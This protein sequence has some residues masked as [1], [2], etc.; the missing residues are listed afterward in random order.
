[1]AVKAKVFEHAISLDREGRVALEGNDLQELDASWTPEHLVLTG[2]ARCSIAS[3]RH[4]ARQRGIEVAAAAS[5]SSRVTRRDDG[6]YGFVTLDVIVDAT[7][8]PAPDDLDE[9]L[10]KA[11]WGCFIG[12]SLTPKPAYT[13]RVNGEQV[14]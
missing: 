6:S 2:L 14:R 1:M 7:L 5:V 13:W 3:L 11:E 4:F 9:L 8:S 10:A 12:A